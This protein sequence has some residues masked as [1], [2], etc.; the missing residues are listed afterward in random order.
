MA[1][2][3]TTFKNVYAATLN[4]EGFKYNSQ[5]GY[6]FRVINKELIQYIT[7]K[8]LSSIERGMKCFDVVAGTVS[9]YSQSIDKNFLRMA[10]RG[11][12]IYTGIATDKLGV[13]YN[14]EESDKAIKK[15]LFKVK[16]AVIPLLNEVVDL[17]S[18]IGFRKK[19]SGFSEIRGGE[20]FRADSLVLIMADNHD[21]FQDV[22]QNEIAQLKELFRLNKIGGTFDEQYAILYDAII[23]KIVKSRDKVYQDKQL[24]AEAIAEAERRKAA[25]LE[26][27]RSMKVID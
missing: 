2:L 27:L 23:C 10:G 12:G 8:T 13:C 22:F 15:T 11:L 26:Y 5:Y 6:F 25:N 9:I 4:R 7:Y 14:E 18:Y 24:Y 20:K 1:T 19:I 3:K 16:D 21:D 17:N